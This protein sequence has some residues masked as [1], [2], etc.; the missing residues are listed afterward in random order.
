MSESKKI[1]QGAVIPEDVINYVPDLP[2]G[3]E[4]YVFEGWYADAA[5]NN[6][7]SFGTMPI[8]GITV[9]AKWRQI[10]YRVF[11]RPNFPGGVTDELKALVGDTNIWGSATQELNFRIPY[12]GK[13]STPRGVI[14][15]Y[16][17][18]GW[19]LDEDGSDVFTD[20][21]SFR[22]DD[23]LL[24]YDNE[25]AINY[26]DKMDQF[27]EGATYNKDKDNNRTWITKKAEIY[28]SWGKVLVGAAGITVIYDVTED[29]VAGSVP[30]DTSN[31]LD[32]TFA[33]AGIAATPADPDKKVFDHWVLQTW[34]GE[35]FVDKDDVAPILPGENFKVYID[36]SKITD[37]S[38]N[39]VAFENVETNKKYTYEVQL[40]AVYKAVEEKTPTH[41][42]WY[43]NN[44]DSKPLDIDNTDG[45]L[46]INAG[47]AIHEAPTWAGYKFLGWAKVTPPEEITESYY[48]QAL[49]EDDLFLVYNE[50]E[51]GEDPYYTA[52]IKN[53]GE[54][55]VITAIY[56][57]ADEK[58]PYNDLFAVWDA[59]DVNYTVEFY[60]QN[61]DG[62]YTKDDALTATRQAATDSP[63]AVE[64]ADLAQTKD[65]SYEFSEGNEKNVLEDTVNA[66]GSTVLKV[67]Y[68]L[69]KADVIV[70]HYLVGQ[71]EPFKTDT[72]EDQI[73]GST[74]TATPEEV[75]PETELA[76]YLEE[77]GDFSITVSADEEENYIYIYY[78]L[79]LT[80]EGED[81]EKTY[82][83]EP[84]TGKYTISG[85]LESDEEY[86]QWLSEELSEEAPSITNVGEGPLD[87]PTEENQPEILEIQEYYIVEFEYESGT[88]TILPR[89]ITLT[90][91]D[92]SKTYDGTPLMNSNVTVGG[93]G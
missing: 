12:G 23:F 66:D 71:E 62:T 7:A 9:Y 11:L 84:L 22:E 50:G 90:S 46:T 15:G 44:G 20:T 5:C 63:V 43:K 91:A 53:N 40:K 42:Y 48:K 1:G 61:L 89:N 68:D 80:I 14:K 34:D 4:G 59:E 79:L 88:L 39:V 26:T 57:A 70:E 37:A 56:V 16:D 83:G 28:G 85:F 74:Y 35:A 75:Y 58:Q 2:A 72:I 3:E 78:K 19:F 65:G 21:T 93:E 45:T 13:V 76:L 29:G 55:T 77:E 30:E 8:G 81:G 41:I 52:T 67:Y 24:P 60:Y 31:Y 17:F 82:D 86:I 69:G 64:E 38:G 73:I 6:E 87:Y 33:L 18:Y 92:D 27:G 47:V 51:E 25:A 54:D 49:T 32:N 10:E 36:D